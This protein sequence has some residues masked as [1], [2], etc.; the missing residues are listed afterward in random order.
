MTAA[1]AYCA[2]TSRR[3][4]HSARSLEGAA[5]ELQR[6]AGS[7]FDP[8]VVDAMIRVLAAGPPDSP[9][10]TFATQLPSVPALI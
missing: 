4:Y 5:E 9:A 10:P 3:P 7:Q 8:V 6:C 1:D 2:M